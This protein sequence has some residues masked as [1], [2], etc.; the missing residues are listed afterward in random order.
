MDF[1]AEPSTKI[2]L[3]NIVTMKQNDL[4]LF[5]LLAILLIT[6]ACVHAQSV[7]KTID[8]LSAPI[9]NIAKP[10]VML[11]GT[12]HFRDAGNDAYKQK[13]S[14]NIQ[15]SK[16]QEEVKELVNILA[17][18]KPTKIAIESMPARQPF[19]DSLYN[20]FRNGRYQLGDN[21][22]Y[23]VAYRLALKMGHQRVYCS[24]AARRDY[25]PKFNADSFATAHHQD[26]Y[27]ESSYGDLFMAVYSKEDS[28]RST[29][30]IKKSLAYENNPERLRFGLGHYLIGGVKV[31]AD[32]AYPGADRTTGWFNRNLRI[33]AN[34]LQLAVTSKDERVLLLIGSGH[35][36]ILRY[37]A[38]SCPEI[39]FVDAYEYLKK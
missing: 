22:I 24:D 3:K 35:V 23:Q 31:A 17:A 12:F 1:V 20:E 5:I 37:L 18:F 29:W 14:V 38:L 36:Q 9:K 33:F 6:G 10:K 2:Q 21:E 28:I 7:D 34:I 39:E 26:N 11:L 19:H 16:R 8:L 25:D 15:S 27:L 4:R 32:G 13:Y 30:P